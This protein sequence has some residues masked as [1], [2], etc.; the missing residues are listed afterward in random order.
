MQSDQLIPKERLHRM[1]LDDQ[2]TGELI[3]YLDKVI[4]DRT[5]LAFST[6]RT[7]PAQLPDIIAELEL[8][9]AL[10]STITTGKFYL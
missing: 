5:S 10:K 1:W 4:R 8:A 2:V 3:N 7:S 9:T 6:R